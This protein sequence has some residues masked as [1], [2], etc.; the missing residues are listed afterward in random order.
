MKKILIPILTT[1]I[2]III[3]QVAYNMYLSNNYVTKKH[4]DK[5]H[6]FL[7]KRID[8]LQ[9]KHDTTHSVLAKH[10][11]KLN[12]I[13]ADITEI[14][15]DAKANLFKTDTIRAENQ[16]IFTEVQKLTKSNEPLWFKVAK[17]L[18]K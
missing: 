2:I 9:T 16:A 11:N 8:T 3:G 17:I 4:F 18:R 13:I 12:G 6:T 10:T 5:A 1:L 15:K 14:K 7:N